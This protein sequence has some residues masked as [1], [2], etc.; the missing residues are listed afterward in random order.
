MTLEVLFEVDTVNAK[1]AIRSTIESSD[2]I[3]K[4]YLG[5]LSDADIVVRP[6]AGM[7]HIAWQLGHLISSEHHMIEA[8]APGSSPAL[9]EDFEAKHGKETSHL[10]D[11]KAFY[12]LGTYLEVWQAQRKST[13]SVLADLDESQLDAPGPER[14]RAYAPTNGA[15]LNMIGVHP[16]MHA[17]QFVAVRRFLNKPITM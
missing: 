13:L 14:M 6:V 8:L 12:P 7:N 10:N 16:L 15:V 17:G 1:D 11:P 4:T 2:N 3:V 5:D 9:P